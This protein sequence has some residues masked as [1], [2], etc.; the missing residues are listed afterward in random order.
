MPIAA[1][2]PM[3]ATTIS[4]STSVSPRLLRSVAPGSGTAFI[5]CLSLMGVDRPRCHCTDDARAHESRDDLRGAYLH[6]T[7]PSPRLF[8]DETR[9]RGDRI[10]QVSDGDS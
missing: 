8:T 6:Q 7:G 5:G 4:N 3:I 9:Q 1:M 2:M 10:R